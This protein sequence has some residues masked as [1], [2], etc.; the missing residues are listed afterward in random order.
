MDLLEDACFDDLCRL[1]PR[2]GFWRGPSLLFF[3]GGPVRTLRHPTGIPHTTPGQAC[4]LAESS[5][6]HERS[7]YLL[8]LVATR[9]GLIW[10][11][12]LAPFL[13]DL[14]HFL[15]VKDEATW[16][17][18]LTVQDGQ[19]FGLTSGIV[20]PSFAATRTPTI[21]NY[22]VTASLWESLTRSLLAPL[23]IRRLPPIPLSSL[24]NTVIRR[25]SPPWIIRISS[26]SCLPGS[27]QKD[28]SSS[29]AVMLNSS[30]STPSLLLA[31]WAWSW[32]RVVLRAWWLTAPSLVSPAT[33]L[34]QIA[35]PTLRWRT[36]SIL[37]RSLTP[38]KGSW[39]WSLMLLRPTAAYS[40]DPPT[41]VCSVSVTVRNCI[42]VSPSI[43]ARGSLLSTGPV[44][45]DF[46]FV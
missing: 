41:G 18:L 30:A 25:G 11:A 6:L 38:L 3:F 31:S 20:W 43:L 22:F 15:Q 27:W 10:Q 39:L 45:R 44:L 8:S 42:S 7:R 35:P 1:W 5:K 28:R 40:F 37:C 34:Y 9:G 12:A 29:R 13:G 33:P 16:E 21:S 24:C 36:C 2:W 4:E 19:P 17:S 14:R 46:W 32:R 23:C 26:M